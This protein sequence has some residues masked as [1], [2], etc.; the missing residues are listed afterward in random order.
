MVAKIT[1]PTR[2]MGAFYY[3]ENKVAEG[4]ATCIHASGFLWE[5][6]EM[7]LIQKRQGF[8]RLHERNERA[9]TKTLH[10]SLN[11]DPSEKL[12][13]E[14]L[15]LI[16]TA[17]VEK[18]GFS[19]QPFLVYRHQDA[20]HPHIH[21][22]TTTIREDG[23]RINTHNIGRN[24]SEKARKEIEKIYGLVVAE[25]KSK[26]NTTVTLP[27]PVQYGLVETKKGISQIV[28]FV[29]PNY[30]FCSIHELNAVLRQF[31]VD[32]STGEKGSR[33][34]KYNG[35]H[36]RMLDST[37]KPIGV[38]I[39]ASSLPGK[40][41]LRKLESYYAKHA[42]IKQH[43]KPYIKSQIVQSLSQ[44]PKDLNELLKLL[45]N[46]NIDLILRKSAD[47]RIYGL[48]FVDHANKVVMNGSD[49][50]KSYSSA[51]IQAQ[52]KA[53]PINHPIISKPS[54]TPDLPFSTSQN[55]AEL[56]LNPID[57]YNHTP[58]QLVKKKRKRKRKYLGL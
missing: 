2:P 53:T 17:Y 8:E 49:L 56:L 58:R 9:K 38:P 12:S 43:C 20:G 35:L 47:G 50:G 24:Q 23:S 51:H 37:G 1:T 3:N 52:L 48:T 30:A 15:R 34:Q 45:K 19:E 22:V 14:K 33:L 7:T 40:P 57:E 26:T 32:A 46:K 29:I 41:T 21:I 10:I 44:Q 25:N 16:A 6:D 39:K 31:G 42:E 11:F 54:I 36:Y 18:I 4:K 13:V 5:Y 28:N 27:T 55:L